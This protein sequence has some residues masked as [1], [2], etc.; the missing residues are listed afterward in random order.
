MQ[1]A[2]QKFG[3][4]LLVLKPKILPSSIQLG[5]PKIS[6][7]TYLFIKRRKIAHSIQITYNYGA[8]ATENTTG[9]NNRLTTKSN[10]LTL[11][12]ITQ[13]KRSLEI[14]MMCKYTK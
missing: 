11:T 14:K 9:E 12:P 7:I 1:Y 8:Y 10:T 4:Y 5:E 13:N 3:N 6:P 2:P